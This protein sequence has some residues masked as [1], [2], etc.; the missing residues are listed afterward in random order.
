MMFVKLIIS[1]AVVAR[2]FSGAFPSFIY[3]VQLILIEKFLK[4][5]MTLAHQLPAEMES[6]S[7]L[8]VVNGF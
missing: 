6:A 4:N 5:L 1:F 8:A 2:V 3:Q 7:L